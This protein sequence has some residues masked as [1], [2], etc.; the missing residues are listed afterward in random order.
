[1]GPSAALAPSPPS[2]GPG[3]DTAY[4]LID[5]DGLM[6]IDNLIDIDNLMDIDDQSQPQQSQSQV[7]SPTTPTPRRVRDD[8]SKPPVKSHVKTYTHMPRPARTPQLGFHKTASGRLGTLT[9][10]AA[11]SSLFAQRSSL[12]RRPALSY[13]VLTQ[14][15]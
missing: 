6:D 14:A 9:T 1:M 13:T 4:G 11:K 5:I 8:S 10:R 15:S 2:Q 12:S 7:L 3:P